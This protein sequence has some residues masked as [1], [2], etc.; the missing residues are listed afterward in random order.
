L[1]RLREAQ[2][3]HAIE[4]DGE[5]RYPEWQFSNEPNRPV[6][7]GIDTVTAAIPENWT[8]ATIN[9]FME[10]PQPTLSIDGLPQTPAQWLDGGGDP[11]KV[12]EIL[13]EVRVQ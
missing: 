2:Y 7:P 11:T 13:H 1:K 8:L 4:H 6:V 3:L 9:A 10:A 12:A 5:L